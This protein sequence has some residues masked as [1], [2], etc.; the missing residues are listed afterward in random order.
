MTGLTKWDHFLQGGCCSGWESRRP[1]Y[2]LGQGED[3]LSVEVALNPILSTRRTW[4]VE[5]PGAGPKAADS[6]V[7]GAGA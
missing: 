2:H 7:S 4:V 1:Q 5:A 6:L 3:L